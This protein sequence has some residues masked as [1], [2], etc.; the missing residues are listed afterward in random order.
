MALAL[1]V[2]TH[3]E[4]ETRCG[5]QEKQGAGVGKI[6][7]GKRVPAHE[8]A[9]I[10]SSPFRVA[11]GLRAAGSRDAGGAVPDGDAASAGSGAAAFV[12]DRVFRGGDRDCAAGAG[13]AALQL[14]AAAAVRHP[15]AGSLPLH[16]PGT[17]ACVVPALFRG[18]CGGL[19]LEP[20]LFLLPLFRVVAAGSGA[21]HASRGSSRATQ[22]LVVLNLVFFGLVS[23][24][25]GN[26]VPW[27]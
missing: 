7:P 19:P 10:G 25:R 24:C 20:A 26:G 1:V 17:P 8:P 22:G 14:A 12:P 3:N 15:G 16:F 13:A 6:G 23:W 4:E 9:S 27:R 21:G 18:V 11:V 5:A 2:S